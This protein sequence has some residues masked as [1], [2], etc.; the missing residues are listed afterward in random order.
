MPDRNLNRAHSALLASV[1]APKADDQVQV[2]KNRIS[3]EHKQ[4]RPRLH[5]HSR[6]NNILRHFL[7]GA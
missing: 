7:S 2:N 6:P 1:T 4:I 5:S 3:S